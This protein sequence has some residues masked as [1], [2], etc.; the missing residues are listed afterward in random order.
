MTD[1]R[2]GPCD[3]DADE[4]GSHWK[5]CH[6][7]PVERKKGEFVDACEGGAT[8]A[9]ESYLFLLDEGMSPTEA[10]EVVVDESG[11]SAACFAGIGSCCGGGCKHG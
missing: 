3:C 7:R 5:G 1:D 2:W 6:L 10:K 11:E 4:F 9:I 8:A